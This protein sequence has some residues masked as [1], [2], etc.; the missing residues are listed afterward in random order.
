[1]MQFDEYKLEE[2]I[3]YSD[4]RMRST[5]RRAVNRDVAIEGWFC[6]PA[7]E[8]GVD[9]EER[10]PVNIL[11]F[12]PVGDKIKAVAV[13]TKGELMI[14]DYSRFKLITTSRPP[15][16]RKA[17]FEARALTQE[18]KEERERAIAENEEK[19]KLIE[20][21]KKEVRFEKG[22]SDKSK[23]YMDECT[24]KIKELTALLDSDKWISAKK[25]FQMEEDIRLARGAI[26]RCEQG[27]E[28]RKKNIERYEKEIAEIEQSIVEIKPSIIV[29]EP[30]IDTPHS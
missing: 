10:V 27:I 18:E 25:R 26:D 15:E 4:G 17:F 12:L 28:S 1:M 19:K 20:Q 3:G 16:A 14:E 29:R 21:K 22:M 6:T 13:N 24:A 9:G 5:L 7:T 23:A 8:D 30:S 2:K 11:Q